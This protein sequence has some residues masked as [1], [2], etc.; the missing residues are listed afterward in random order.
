MT[1]PL[2]LVLLRLQCIQFWTPHVKMD[3]EV[4]EHAQRRATRLIKGL[5]NTS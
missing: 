3:I 5:E 1:I 4:L 2:H